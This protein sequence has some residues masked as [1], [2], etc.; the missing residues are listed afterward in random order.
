MV[1]EFCGGGYGCPSDCCVVQIYDKANLTII[2]SPENYSSLKRCRAV[3]GDRFIHSI[4]FVIT[5][6]IL[7]SDSLLEK[8]S[9]LYISVVRLVEQYTVE[10]Q[11]AP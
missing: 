3:K 10:P 9:Q 4:L 6:Y 1:M 2:I 11:Y 7:T 8:N 5:L